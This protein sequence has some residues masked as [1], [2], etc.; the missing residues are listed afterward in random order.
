[1]IVYN[2][3]RNYGKF[4]I[5]WI[6]IDGIVSIWKRV[7]IVFEKNFMIFLTVWITP[8]VWKIFIAIKKTLLRRVKTLLPHVKPIPIKVKTFSE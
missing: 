7:G 2:M 5:D 8:K 1:M 3:N 4:G 6:H